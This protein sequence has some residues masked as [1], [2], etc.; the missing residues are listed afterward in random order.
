MMSALPERSS[1]AS[2]RKAPAKVHAYSNGIP[3]QNWLSLFTWNDIVKINAAECQKGKVEHRLMP[4]SQKAMTVWESNQKMKISLKQALDICRVCHK[5][6]PFQFFNGN[7]FTFLARNII[8]D[9]I[10]HLPSTKAHTFRSCVAHYVAGRLPPESFEQV[11][12][13]IETALRSKN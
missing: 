5:L 6:A 10:H 1:K 11:M 9:L 8:S 12:S 13:S 7:T 3:E 2:L 4:G